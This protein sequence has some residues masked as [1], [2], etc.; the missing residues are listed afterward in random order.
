MGLRQIP[1]CHRGGVTVTE[2]VT[3]L[4]TESAARMSDWLSSVQHTEVARFH[5]DWITDIETDASRI[6]F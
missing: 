1:E 4:T 3:I 2:A 5:K 6:Y